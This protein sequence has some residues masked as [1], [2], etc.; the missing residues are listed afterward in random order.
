MPRPHQEFRCRIDRAGR[1]H[2]NFAQRVWLYRSVP[3]ACTRTPSTAMVTLAVNLLTMVL[4]ERDYRAAVGTTCRRAVTLASK[5]AEDCLLT[6]PD[7]S[8]VM[9]RDAIEAWIRSRTGGHVSPGTVSRR[10]PAGQRLRIR[11]PPVGRRG[12]ARV[13]AAAQ[14][15]I[16]AASVMEG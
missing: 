12:P 8:W 14:L 4:A 15:A 10:E 5:F 7:G 9:P 13:R 3:M 16:R 2:F 6:A 1:Q 11:R